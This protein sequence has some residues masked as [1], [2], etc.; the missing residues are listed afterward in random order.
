MFVIT[1][2]GYFLFLLS[3]ELSLC[4]QRSNTVVFI[5]L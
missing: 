1:K 3:I 2:G 4:L 5:D